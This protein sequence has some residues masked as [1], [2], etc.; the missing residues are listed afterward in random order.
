MIEEFPLNIHG[1]HL[2]LLNDSKHLAH[3]GGQAG[4]VRFDSLGDRRGA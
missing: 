1:S 2:A 3:F 4:P